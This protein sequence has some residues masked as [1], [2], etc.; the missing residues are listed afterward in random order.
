MACPRAP[1]YEAVLLDAAP[2]PSLRYTN[3]LH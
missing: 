2:W 3:F 1:C